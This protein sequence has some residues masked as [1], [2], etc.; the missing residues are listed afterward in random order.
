MKGMHGSPVVPTAAMRIA[1]TSFNVQ[2]MAAA[3]PIQNAKE[4][5]MIFI[6]KKFKETWNELTD[7]KAPG[8]RLL[9]TTIILLISVLAL[10]LFI[11]YGPLKPWER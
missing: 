2:Y 1:A 3:Q 6:V 4:G 8:T 9:G 7:P 5:N 11:Q 10:F